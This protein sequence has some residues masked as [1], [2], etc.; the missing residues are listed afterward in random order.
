MT[1]HIA[2][3]RLATS[4]VACVLAIFLNT[5]PAS[6]Q[7]RPRGEWDQAMAYALNDLV[8]SRGSTYRALRASTNKPPGRTAPS[9][10]ADWEAFATGYNN[11]GFW[12]SIVQYN[13]N[14]VVVHG[15]SAWVALLTSTGRAPH[16]PGSAGFWLKLVPGLAAKGP[17]STST[18]YVTDDVVTRSGSTWRAKRGSTGIIPGTSSADWEQLAARGATGPAGPQGP[19]GPVGPQGPEGPQGPQGQEGPQGPQGPPGV[20]TLQTVMLV[21]AFS[22]SIGT[23]P[24]N[25]GGYVFVGG[26][27]TWTVQSSIYEQ[28]LIASATVGLGT[29]SA[30]NANFELGICYQV[31]GGQIFLLGQVGVNAGVGQLRMPLTAT[32]AKNIFGGTYQVGACVKNFGIVLDNNTV[33]SGWFMT[34]R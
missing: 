15:G 30:T 24:A 20:E 16:L 5:L 14:D 29:H 3:G 25:T 21:R 19:R 33:S 13:P 23:I 10:A 34:T 18:S 27:Y 8:T 4:L 17:W 2:T 1:S 9:T 7:L 11:L 26:T 31:D 12:S 6:A 32:G 28:W 22:G